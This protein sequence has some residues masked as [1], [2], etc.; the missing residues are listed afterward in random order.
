MADPIVISGFTIPD[1]WELSIEFLMKQGTR[2][3]TEYD[4]PSSP[5][6]VDA[7]VALLIK[8]PTA[9]PSIHKCIPG[10]TA[11]LYR[12]VD[13]VLEGTA[14]DTI[15]PFEDAER[16][17][18]LY[19]TYHQRMFAYPG[20]AGQVINQV[21]SVI[22]TLVK[23]PYSRRAQ[24]VVWVPE[25]DDKASCPPCLQSLWFRVVED[26][27]GERYLNMNVRMRSNDAYNAAFMNMFAFSRL[28]AYIADQISERQA[29]SVK[30]GEY[31]HFADSYH[32]Y[33]KDIPKIDGLRKRIETSD[34]R[35][36]TL[37]S[38]Y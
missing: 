35:S 17:G 30:V 20:S 13:E 1:V 7:S 14:D 3:R 21:D 36:R 10:T 23:T 8:T 9:E 15:V 24:V 4:M 34:F 18:H 19:Y 31:L 5:P 28:Q 37:Q 16:T 2:I 22:R 27:I 26:S 6:S 12:Y 38:I 25:L 32:I 33:G 11:F 29:Q